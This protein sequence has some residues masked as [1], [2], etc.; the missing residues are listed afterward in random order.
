[1]KSRFLRVADVAV[2]LGVSRG[3]AYGLVR[4][5]RIPAVRQGRGVRIPAEAFE[6]WMKGRV[7]A[8]LAAV[9][10]AGEQT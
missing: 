3:R 10:E 4:E 1:M 6:A 7:E 9:R 8:A 5:G 2:Q